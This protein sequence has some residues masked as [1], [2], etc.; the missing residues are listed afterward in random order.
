MGF[1]FAVNILSVS[2]HCTF[3][4]KQ[5]CCNFTIGKAIDHQLHNLFFACRQFYLLIL[6]EFF[7][8]TVHAFG[9]FFGKVNI[10]VANKRNSSHQFLPRNRFIKIA[11]DPNIVNKFI[12]NFRITIHRK[13]NNF[14]VRKIFFQNFRTFQSVY[15]GHHQIEQNHVGVY[16]AGLQ[17]FDELMAVIIRFR[18][19][20][21]FF[22]TQQHHQS[23][24]DDIMIVNNSKLILFFHDIKEEF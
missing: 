13:N 10:A 2:F 23:V 6:D 12:D 18:D 8:V 3:T 9:R 7:T 11:L 21:T 16:G 5:F 24:H 1:G 15:F 4:D 19:F 17:F 20:D 14:N 22:K